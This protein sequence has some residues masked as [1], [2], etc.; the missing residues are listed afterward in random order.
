MM[1]VQTNTF[2]FTP[3]CGFAELLE[4]STYLPEDL[5][6]EKIEKKKTIWKKMM[7]MMMI[8]RGG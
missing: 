7:S 8:Q 4:R 5:T 1:N 2:I 6:E 3:L